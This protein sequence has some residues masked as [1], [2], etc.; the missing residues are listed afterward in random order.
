MNVPITLHLTWPTKCRS[1]PHD[2]YSLVP[3]T[4]GQLNTCCDKH[5][6]LYGQLA[7]MLAFQ[8]RLVTE[9]YTHLCTAVIRKAFVDNLTLKP[10]QC[11]E[12]NKN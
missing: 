12:L 4:Q 3:V 10:F 5:S 1:F 9:H 2:V 7:E 8:S 6:A 11:F